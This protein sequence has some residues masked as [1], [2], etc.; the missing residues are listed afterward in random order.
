MSE[1]AVRLVE[2]LLALLSSPGTLATFAGLVAAG[3]LVVLATGLRWSRYRTRGART[4][5][6]YTILY[7]GGIYG[8]IWAVVIRP[9]ASMVGRHAPFLDVGLLTAAPAWLRLLL[10]TVLLDGL[11]YWKHRLMHRVGFLWRC[12]AIHHSQR[13][14]TLLTGYRFHPLDELVASVV[15]FALGLAIGVAP[16][17]GVA[18][19]FGVAVYAALQ[20]EDTGW[21]Y[22]PLGLVLVSP[23]FHSVH[24]AVDAELHD[25]NYGILF[26]IWDRLFG[27]AAPA[28]SRVKGYGVDL[29]VPESFLSQLL[30]PFRRRSAAAEQAARPDEEPSAQRPQHDQQDARGSLTRP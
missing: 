13:S 8:L 5:A 11:L 20:H 2:R 26:S 24:H 14:L 1:T 19:T 17:M 4:D 9:L 10:F 7:A 29:E 12:H 21:S 27:T 23:R 25:R 22:G 3:L 6:V 28:P 18:L 16:P 15:G 30:F